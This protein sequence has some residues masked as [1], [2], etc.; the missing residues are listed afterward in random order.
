MIDHEGTRKLLLE[1][2]R[3]LRALLAEARAGAARL[4]RG[5]GSAGELRRRLGELRAACEEHMR[6]E[7]DRLAP[8][9]ARIDAWGP[10][11]LER[12]REEHAHQRAALARLA[13][14]EPG[15]DLAKDAVALAEVLESEMRAEERDIL[16]ASVL[17]DDPLTLDASDA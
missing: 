3:S 13:T 11:R 16:D 15:T 17:R 6:D 1:Q 7:E 8:V 4:S 5:E 12:M 9:L 10:E 2:H 14:E